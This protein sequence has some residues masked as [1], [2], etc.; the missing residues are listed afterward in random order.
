MILGIHR[1]IDRPPKGFP[2]YVSFS[3]FLVS[4]V[5][6]DGS[7]RLGVLF[8]H[9]SSTASLVSFVGRAVDFQFLVGIS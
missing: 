5:F 2:Y 8:F 9:R 7:L 6:I 4:S 3:L 1:K